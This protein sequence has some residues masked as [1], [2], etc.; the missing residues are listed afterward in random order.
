VRER[1]KI[2]SSWPA[3]QE[4]GE[5]QG[6]Y[7]TLN[8]HLAAAVFA[9]NYAPLAHTQFVSRSHEPRIGVR[10]QSDDPGP[11]PRALEFALKGLKTRQNAPK[12]ID[13]IEAKLLYFMQLM[14]LTTQFVKIRNFSSRIF[15]RVGDCLN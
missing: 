9:G 6:C 1:R 12:S 11:I 15:G 8:Q 5:L 10:F 2:C 14:V 7:L 3:C 13:F 4:P